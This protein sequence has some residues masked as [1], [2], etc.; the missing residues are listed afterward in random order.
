M[1]FLTNNNNFGLAMAVWLAHDEYTN[2]AE[3]FAGKNVISMTTLLKPTRATILAL[4][5]PPTEEGVGD[6]ADRIKAQIGHAIHDAVEK[7]WV[8]GY[9]PAMEKLRVPARVIEKIRVNPSNVDPD[10]IPVHF[11]QRKF[12]SVFVDGYEVIIS[13]K[14]DQV[15]DGELNDTKSTSTYT[16]INDTKSDDYIKQL[17]GYRW[18]DPETITSDQG[19]INFVFLDW[20]RGKVGTTE[21]YPSSQVLEKVYNLMP[22]EQTEQWITSKVRELIK[23]QNAPEEDL[24]RCTD[25]ELWKTDPV[26]KYYADPKKA[27]EGARATKNFPNYPAAVQYQNVTKKGKGCIITVP[28]Q[29]KACSYCPAFEHCTQK[30]EYDHG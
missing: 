5:N 28:G 9:K 12:R 15:L 3:E 1:S 2:G 20:M 25:K 10:T 30:D 17:S 27:Q 16:Y 23:Y 8:E 4:R 18:L 21:N 22:L 26:Y 11:E 14:Y 6:V 13:G 7:A 19:R 24:P 29:V